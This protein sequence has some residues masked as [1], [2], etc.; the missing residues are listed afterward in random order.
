MA[1]SPKADAIASNYEAFEAMLPE[2]LERAPGKYALLRERQLAGLFDTA[3]AAHAAG[4]A[5]FEDGLYSVQKVKE[6]AA[7][8]GFFSYARYCGAI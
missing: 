6:G 4:A 1:L 7:A 8:S 5:R 3:R 2:L